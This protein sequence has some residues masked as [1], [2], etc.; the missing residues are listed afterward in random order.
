MT[1]EVSNLTLEQLFEEYKKLPDWDRYPLPE[2]YYKHFNIRKPQ[3]ASVM[4]SVCYNP[5]PY[6]SLNKDGKVELREPAPGGVR[7]IKDLQSL[8]VETKLIT[9]DGTEIALTDIPEDVHPLLIKAIE[10]HKASITQTDGDSQQGSDQNSCSPPTEH[11]N[12]ETQPVLDP[13]SVGPFGV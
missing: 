4:E 11:S 10:K 6:Q 9:E 7:E 13:L 3:A 1:A 12:S 8:P 5:P 2:V